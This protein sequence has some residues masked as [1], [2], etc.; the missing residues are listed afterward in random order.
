MKKYYLIFIFLQ[1]H[2]LIFAQKDTLIFSA[3]LE[4]YYTY[5]FGKNSEKPSYFCS[6]HR[7]NEIN[8]NIGFLK[9]QYQS[10][11]TRTNFAFMAG[12]YS[13][14][15][16]A[17]EPGVLKNIFEANIGWKIAKQRE[18]WLDAGVFPSHIGFESAIG[19]DC[20]NLTRS[21][22]ADNSPYFESGIRISYT[23]PQNNWFF[24]GLLLNGWQQIQRRDHIRTPA[25]GHQ[26]VFTQSDY[27]LL[28][29][30]SFI[31]EV[32]SDSIKTIRFFHNFY[33]QLLLS[34][35][36]NFTIGFDIGLQQKPTK[37]WIVW[38]SPVVIAQYKLHDRAKIALRGEYYRDKHQNIIQ[39]PS[40]EGFSTFS[41]SLNYDY[42]LA[43]KILWRLEGRG[44]EGHEAIFK[45][46]Q[47]SFSKR[48]FWI[49]TSLAISF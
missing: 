48:A 22:L 4:T 35:K 10:E 6:Y 42:W 24:A 27:L 33:G 28:N 40:I 13:N 19:K 25:W 21:I 46:Y 14:T 32:R 8:L 23:N 26:I 31:G 7:N 2:S 18:I 9:V 12:T 5:D 43:P 37:N 44:F 39:V 41:Y 20:W 15:N 17:N 3:Y 36:A 49:T 45:S 30:S 11:R 1:V 38:Y 16:L 47:N 29:S 34:K